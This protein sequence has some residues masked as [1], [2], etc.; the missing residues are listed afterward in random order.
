MQLDDN[1]YLKMTFLALGN[2]FSAD[3]WLVD[4]NKGLSN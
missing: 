1:L 3:S 2:F 4:D